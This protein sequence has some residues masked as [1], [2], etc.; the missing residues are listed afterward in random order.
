[1]LDK[2]KRILHGVRAYSPENFSSSAEILRFEH[3]EIPFSNLFLMEDALNLLWKR[4]SSYSL[5]IWN[6]EDLEFYISS[7][8]V[9][10]LVARLSAVYPSPEVERAKS[11]L[12]EIKGYAACGFIKLEGSPLG[13]KSLE[14]F[15]H[16]PLLHMISAMRS[17]SIIQFTFKPTRTVFETFSG[18][19]PV[20]RLRIIAAV[21]SE[22][23]R[24]ALNECEILL[25]SFSIFNGY[26]KLKPVM[27][28]LAR[29]SASILARASSRKLSPFEGFKI[30]LN[31]LAATAHFPAG[32]FE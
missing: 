17:P 6:I 24:R 22:N 32:G 5:E 9:E 2:I 8:N 4:K 25:R 11:S 15:D 20:F 19:I 10:E 26:A 12:P 16:D 29:S 3:D 21:F 7:E 18:E 31:S 23:W 14:D 30:S 27:C 28:N 1:M 13:L